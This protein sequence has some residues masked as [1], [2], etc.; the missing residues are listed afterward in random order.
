MAQVGRNDPCPCG[1]GKKYKHCCAKAAA[2]AAVSPWHAIDERLAKE[3]LTFVR[4]R[5]DPSFQ[6]AEVFPCEPTEDDLPLFV[7]WMLYELPFEGARRVVDA[8]LSERGGR[9]SARD[10]GWLEAN[11][12]SS[13]SLWQVTSVDRGHGLT[14]IDRLTGIERTVH[15]IGASNHVHEGVFM[16]ARVVDVEGVS[17]LGGAHPRALSAQWGART[18]SEARRSLRM[19]KKAVS[20]ERLRKPGFAEVL[21]EIWLDALEEMAEAPPPQL[22]NTDG[23]PLLWTKDHFSIYPDARERVQECLAAI[24]T[25]T[26]DESGD[27]IAITIARAGNPMHAEWSNTILGRVVIKERTLVIESNSIRRADDLRASIEQRLA[28]HGLVHAVR[29]RIRDHEDLGARAGARNAAGALPPRREVSAEQARMVRSVKAAHY[30][31]WVDRPLP[32]LRGKTP[33]EVS[34]NVRGRA[35]LDRLLTEM[36]MLE[37]GVPE[38]ERFDVGELRRELGM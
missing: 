38:Q 28:E 34:R 15:E 29:H 24:E 26:V 27:A 19:R 1:S 6:P 17:V 35:E 30:S 12:R 2:P 33:R 8:Y 37:A 21:I 11:T 25:A 36:E 10:R 31:D 4:K 23:D 20:V 18:V 13:L 22:Q 16:L 3:M 5:G 32:I 9:L 14:L 7:P